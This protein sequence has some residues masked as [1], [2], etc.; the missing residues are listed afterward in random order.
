MNKIVRNV[1]AVITGI[2]LG[3]AVNMGII[4]L[5]G[6]F[7]ALP[8]GV[9]VTNTESLQSSMHLFGPKHFIF[10]FLAHAI[11][12]LV[13]AY[14]SA[15]I[16]ANHKMQFALGIGIFFLIG[17]ISMVFMMPAPVWFLI[18]D[19][20]VAYVPMGWLSGRLATRS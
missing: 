18:L 10:P 2:I 16:A 7:I 13:G 6:Y 12:T 9:D 1:L 17:G 14:L 11:G 4:M 3:S 20:S 15:R 5:Q 8:E 19:L